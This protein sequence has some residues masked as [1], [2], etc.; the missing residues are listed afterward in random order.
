MAR[1]AGSRGGGRREEERAWSLR[2][3]PR[4]LGWVRYIILELADARGE[5]LGSL[6]GSVCSLNWKV[7]N[8]VVGC[9]G[10]A[11]AN[12][13]ADDVGDGDALDGRH[14]EMRVGFGCKDV[15]GAVAG[16]DSCVIS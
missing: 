14:L 15:A 3:G 2:V 10:L 5:R 7:I 13:D 11:Y 8:V 9:G 16:R 1:E 4:R 12:G 6:A